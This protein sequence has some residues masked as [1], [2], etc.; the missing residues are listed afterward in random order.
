M[1]DFSRFP[2][3]NNVIQA[4]G[5]IKETKFNKK[6]IAAMDRSWAA[7]SEQDIMMIDRVIPTGKRV[8]NTVVIPAAILVYRAHALIVIPA[9]DIIWMYSHVVRQSMYFIPTSKM[10]T[11]RMHL[12]SGEVESLDAVTTGGFSKKTPADD[13]IAEILSVIGQYYPGMLI[14]WSEELSKAASNNFPALVASVDSKNA[15]RQ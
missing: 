13:A 15:A 4:F 3:I 7:I 8:L 6:A 1:T 10:H 14:G 2:N 5:G 9:R 11:V 12:R